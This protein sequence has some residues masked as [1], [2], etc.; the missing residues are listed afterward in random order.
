MRIQVKDFMSTSVLTVDANTTLGEVRALMNREGI[1][2]LPIADAVPLGTTSIQGIIT[3]SDLSAELSDALTV[4]DILKP[5]RVHVIPPNTNAQSAAKNM[6][7]HEVHHLV[8]MEDGRI[9]GMISSQ[10]FVKL[11]A[12]HTLDSKANTII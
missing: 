9:V 6:L 7:K 5:G 10:D 1:H 8:V 3:G 11:V 4:G 2:A 12:D